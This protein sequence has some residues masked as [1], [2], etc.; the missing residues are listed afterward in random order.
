MDILSLIQLQ[1]KTPMAVQMYDLNH[2]II[3]EMKT[4][5]PLHWYQLMF[6]FAQKHDGML[7]W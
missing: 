3:S 2:Y 6:L 7:T 4:Q 1:K 5:K